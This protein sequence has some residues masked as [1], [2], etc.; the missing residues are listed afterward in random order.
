MRRTFDCLVHLLNVNECTSHWF[1]LITGVSLIV[2]PL[3]IMKWISI[4]MI[5]IFSKKQ[6]K[7]C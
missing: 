5:L 4:N 6:I 7:K 1:E 3:N 2:K